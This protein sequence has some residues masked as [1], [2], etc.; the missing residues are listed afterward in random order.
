MALAIYFGL[1]KKK[2][3]TITAKKKNQQNTVPS[4][5]LF[6]DYFTVTPNYS[7]EVQITAS[8]QSSV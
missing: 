1:P 8:L 4:T 5:H 3:S 6:R 2:K 7:E